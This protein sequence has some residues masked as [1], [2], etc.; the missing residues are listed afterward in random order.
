M[1]T[2]SVGKCKM[3]DS[4]APVLC[5]RYSFK[6]GKTL[7]KVVFSNCQIKQITQHLLQT[8]NYILLQHTKAARHKKLLQFSTLA[9]EHV[10]EVNFDKYFKY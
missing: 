1:R 7:F 9:M 8:H 5:N 6:G 10:G 3:R 4:S 2:C